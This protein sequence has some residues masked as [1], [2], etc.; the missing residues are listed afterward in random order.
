MRKRVKRL[1]GVVDSRGRAF[2]AL[3]AAAW[4]LLPV[5]PVFGQAAVSHG[6]SA[7]GD[8]KYPAGFTHFEYVDPDAPKGGIVSSYTLGTFDS[9]NAYILK[10]TPVQPTLLGLL[11]DTLMVRAY[12]EPDA[13]Y[14]LLAREA[15]LAD[16]GSWVE[17]VLREEA[18]FADGNP[19]TAAD[20]VFSLE[21]LKADGS[22]IWR[23]RLADIKSAGVRSADTVRFHFR[24]GASVRDLPLQAAQMPVFSAAYWEGRSFGE[25][26]LEA[27]LGSGPYRV[28]EAEQ[29]RRIVFARRPDYWARDLPV[30][31][32][33]Y[34]FDHIAL[35]YFRDHNAAF[36]AFKAGLYLFREEFV[37]KTW[38]TQYSFPAV[39]D[40]RVILDLVPDA[41][42]SG[43]QG[44]W[45]N[46]R[47]ARF[48]DPLVREAMN[49]AF[50]FEWTNRTLFHD[51]YH[52]TDSFFEG[53]P[54]EATGAA[55]P[56]ERALLE[57]VGARLPPQHFAQA[58]R[59]PV[60]D[61]SGRARDNFRRAGALL[62]A[63]GWRPAA[64]GVRVDSGGERLVVEFLIDAPSFERI[65]QPY[66]Q[67][68][69][70]VGFE[71]TLTRVDAA[72][73]ES[74]REAFDYDVVVQRFALPATPGVGLRAFFHSSSTDAPGSFNLSGVRDP[75]VDRLVMA[76][77]A[78]SSRPDLAVA[79]RALDRALRAGHY[80]VPHWALAQHRIAFWDR[81]GR[82]PRK[83]PYAPAFFDTWWEDPER[84]Q[85]G[86]G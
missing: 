13:I 69:R 52:R 39:V 16:D 77:I 74:R 63:A 65:V 21:A 56:E 6:L 9:L 35:E 59:S 41:R 37:S 70:R 48:A 15:R 4:V 66:L 58:Y 53:S 25:S 29:G 20:V 62:D 31:R 75:A 38:A 83:P 11:H 32:G 67:N 10:G 43:T 76:A 50:D 28:E 42:P 72:Q 36:E 8:L 71:A 44:F 84:A 68:L 79:I 82:P 1:P 22:A 12:D 60:T 51:Q 46:T 33:R 40:G 3:L 27:P 80:W 30:N 24:P 18:R 5:Q 55:G 14:G 7:F 86:G 23:Q 2:R 73:Y 34:N 57:A 81:F 19:V 17:F 54:F 78:A 26:T 45:I 61:G 49:L 64:D 85:D 47:R